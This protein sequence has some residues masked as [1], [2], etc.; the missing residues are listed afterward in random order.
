MVDLTISQ[1]AKLA[2]VSKTTVSRVLNNKGEI[3]EETRNRV[4]QVI[5]ENHYRP[6]SAAR[7]IKS[8]E[9]KT[10]GLLIP[11]EADYIMSNPFYYDVI[12]GIATEVDSKNYYLLLMYSRQESYLEIVREKRIDGLLLLS[13][14]NQH[15]HLLDEL[16]QTGIP[17]VSLSA[18]PGNLNIPTVS[19]NDFSGA[20]KAVSYLVKQGHR[21]IA[22]LNGP[23]NLVSNEERFRGYCSV[24]DSNGIPY[25]DDFVIECDISV[26]NGRYAM[27]E[28]LNYP[29]LTAVF[30]SG[31]LMAIGAIEAIRHSGK[32]IPDD[33]SIVAYDNIA[34][35]GYLSP[36]LTT[37]NQF[38]EKKGRIAANTLIEQLEGIETSN[39]VIIEPKLVVR[40][41]TAS[42][43]TVS[44]TCSN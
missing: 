11:Y 39:Y 42:P 33:I 37:V 8:R 9:T 30:V 40:D 13:L 24:L 14:G 26:K 31:D 16:V 43:H 44:P 20:K 7:T 12:R 18:V 5:S 25:R 23:R 38:G 22:L 15:L 19:V 35:S 41:S 21:N 27:E 17:M 4:L 1:I 32:R 29:E 2:G 6:N 3:K 36:A 34:M 28:F 10:I